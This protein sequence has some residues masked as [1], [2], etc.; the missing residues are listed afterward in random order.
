MS[1]CMKTDTGYVHLNQLIPFMCF[2][3][4]MRIIYTMI[5]N[6][7]HSGGLKCPKRVFYSSSPCVGASIW[8]GLL[9]LEFFPH[10]STCW[11][12]RI[13][14][15]NKL[16]MT[17]HNWIRFRPVS[18]WNFAVACVETQGFEQTCCWIQIA[19]KY[20]L[21]CVH[22]LSSI[23]HEKISVRRAYSILW[24][25]QYHTFPFQFPCH[26]H[27]QNKRKQLSCSLQFRLI[28]FISTFCSLTYFRC[29]TNA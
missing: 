2:F 19:Y 12:L 29:L 28:C 17:Y 27:L 3:K 21:T 25:A 1:A 13:S 8:E 15:S 14:R 5:L 4:W 11:L 18:V 7:W 6:L 22:Q 23:Q 20:N 16:T 26:G 9:N 10:A 24:W